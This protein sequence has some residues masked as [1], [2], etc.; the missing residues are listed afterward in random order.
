MAQ[1]LRSF[2]SAAEEAGKVWRV[3]REQSVESYQVK[4]DGEDVKLRVPRQPR[5]RS[6]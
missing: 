3:T 2:L 4:L 6:E 1:D 5:S